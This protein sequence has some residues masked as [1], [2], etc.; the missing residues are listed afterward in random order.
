MARISYQERQRLI[1][2]RAAQAATPQPEELAVS[3]DSEDC[4]DGICVDCDRETPVE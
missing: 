2:E 3:V 4:C 1:A